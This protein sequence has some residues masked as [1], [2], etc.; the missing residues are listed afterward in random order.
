M[1]ED[2]PLDGVGARVRAMRK[3]QPNLTQQQLADKAH[4]SLSLVKAVEQGR[5]PATAA[6]V[7]AVAPALGVTVYDLYNQPSPRYGAERAGIAELETAVMAGP[8]LADDGPPAALAE[9][10]QRESQVFELVRRCRYDASSRQLPVLL[11]D[12]HT[13]AAAAPPGAALERAHWLLAEAYNN[14]MFCLYRLGS[15]LAGQA[16]ERSA[17]AARQGGDPLLAARSD[18]LVWL[19]L[20]H[21]GAYPEATRVVARAQDSIADQPAG[22]ET[23]TIRGILHLNSAI[24]AA[25]QGSAGNAD[26]HLTEAAD[27]ASHLPPVSDLYGTA[28][29]AA[30]VHIHSVAAAVEMADG[31][32]AVGRDAA[33]T[34]PP[35]TPRRRLGHHHVDL[36]R[37][38]L[39]HG[40]RDRA[41]AELYRARELTPQLV[42]YHPQVHETL[43]TLAETDRRRSD[44]LAGFARW[45]GVRY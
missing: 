10:G 27:L 6:F 35:D 9:L 43:A 4:V 20:M 1:V 7:A 40:D 12:L 23:F 32:T 26:A 38:W 29:C 30:N 3:L 14:A 45:A 28:F 44:S 36:A 42:R 17:A 37:A 41:L 24:V 19:P 33:T 2:S 13:A 5:A 25:R 21:R 39:L 11:A 8:A 16:A 34:L 22:P 15:T 18:G 31:T